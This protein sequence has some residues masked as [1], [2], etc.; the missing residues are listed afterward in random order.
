M[1]TR[2]EIRRLSHA[3]CEF[4]VQHIDSVRPL[5]QDGHESITRR[6][7]VQH[8][9]IRYEPPNAH[10]PRG[11]VL[12]EFGRQAVCAICDMWLEALLKLHYGEQFTSAYGPLNEKN[13]HAIR[14][15]INR[16]PVTGTDAVESP[17][18]ETKDRK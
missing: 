2:R 6:L 13:L 17:A 5:R 9:Y 11:T 12:T 18:A 16:R 7:M 14:R 1:I 15:R 8:E 10:R 4:L 3:Q